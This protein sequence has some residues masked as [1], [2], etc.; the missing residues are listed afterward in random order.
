MGSRS[1]EATGGA[2]QAAAS[3]AR[4]TTA[5][6]RRARI[7]D[8][9]TRRPAAA[10]ASITASATN[11]LAKILLG[12]TGLSSPH[13]GHNS[14]VHSAIT[15]SSDH[16]GLRGSGGTGACSLVGLAVEQHDDSDAHD[17]DHCTGGKR[18]AAACSGNR[19][20]H[21]ALPPSP[22]AEGD[23]HH[24]NADHDN[25]RQP[26]LNAGSVVGGDHD[27]QYPQTTSSCRTVSSPLK[28]ARRPAR[29]AA[30]RPPRNRLRGRRL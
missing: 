28:G 17:E 11:M 22:N 5:T 4:T 18:P 7:C 21:W 29:S 3:E 27:E 13:S 25:E 14:H 23:A 10:A 15:P 19:R 2:T 30:G 8:G 26:R 6:R 12:R 9:A 24:R 16:W 1:R 20:E